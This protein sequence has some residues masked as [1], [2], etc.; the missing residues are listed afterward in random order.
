MKSSARGSDTIERQMSRSALVL[1]F[2]NLGEASELQRGS[3]PPDVPLGRHR[4]VTEALPKLLDELDAHALRAT[5]FI[6]AINC[7]MYPHA[8]REIA[9]RG[10][11]IGM[12][13][14]RHEAWAQLSAAHEAQLLGHGMRSFHSIGIEVVGFRPP[15]GVLT[16]SSPM[17]LRDCGISYCSPEG[18][19]FELRDGIAYI[20]F[21]WALVDAYY[22]MEQF[23]ELRARRGD[24]PET[25]DPAALETQMVAELAALPD[26][27][28]AR[29]VILHPFLMLDPRWWAAVQR[30]LARVGAMAASGEAWVGPARTFA[31]TV[32]VAPASSS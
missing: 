10:H 26:I 14:W 1:T 11:E 22:L 18:N 21:E 20:P 8:M 23:G 31:D 17:L 32:R 7:E 4:S 24:P 25:A 29:T 2:D 3:W 5:F 6:E 27:R 30:L 12:H 9:A 15:G 28:R 19:A 13:G 16:V